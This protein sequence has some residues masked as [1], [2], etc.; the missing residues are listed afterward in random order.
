MPGDSAAERAFYFIACGIARLVYRVKAIG[1]E[2]LPC[3][4]CLLVPNHISW[5]D[6][7]VLQLG[8]PRPVRFIIDEE[9]YQNRIL[10]PILHMARAIPINR[11]RPREA[12]RRAA[13]QIQ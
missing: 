6:A 13:T 1:V 12:I 2:N 3:G 8:C 10:H 5:V 9:F 7:I 11:T 4:G